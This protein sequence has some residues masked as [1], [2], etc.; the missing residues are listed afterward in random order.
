MPKF[1]EFELAKIRSHQVCDTSGFRTPILHDC[2]L[3]SGGGSDLCQLVYELLFIHQ[4]QAVCVVVIC[5][6]EVQQTYHHDHV[7]DCDCDYS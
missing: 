7:H 2:R 6:H 4:W 1:A 3:N 5:C